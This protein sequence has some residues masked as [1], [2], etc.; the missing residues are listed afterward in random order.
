MLDESVFVAL[1]E[2]DSSERKESWDF[3]KVRR[4]GGFLGVSD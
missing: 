2:R 4:R 1:L 3:L